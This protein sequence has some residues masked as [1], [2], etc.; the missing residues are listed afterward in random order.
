[1][2]ELVPFWAIAFISLVLSTLAVDYAAH[3]AHLISPSHQVETV[4]V[5]FANFITYAIIW[6]A[7]FLLFNRYLF[8]THP[9]S[10]DEV[11]TLS[12]TAGV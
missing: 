3:E 5:L 11:D 4:L 6:V 12:S 7:K 1:M 8:I 10:K 9:E 2:R